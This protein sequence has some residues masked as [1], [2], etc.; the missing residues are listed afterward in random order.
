MSTEAAWAAATPRSGQG[1][2]DAGASVLFESFLPRRTYFRLA[3]GQ[4]PASLT[5]CPWPTAPTFP[6]K[7]PTG[8]PL[9]LLLSRASRVRLCATP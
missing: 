5:E 9:L 1:R 7:N 3:D 8:A 4:L 2:V 6:R